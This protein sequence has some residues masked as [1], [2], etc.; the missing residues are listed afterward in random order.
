[1]Q[2]NATEELKLNEIQAANA[3]LRE[4]YLY[5]IS[6]MCGNMNGKSLYT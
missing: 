1:M 6:S 2:L 5:F 4:K 3:F